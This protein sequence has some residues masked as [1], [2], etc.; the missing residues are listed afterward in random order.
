ME[1]KQTPGDDEGQGS[2]CAVVRGV[3]ESDTT[4]QLINNMTTISLL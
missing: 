4:K 2:L 1:S 3:T